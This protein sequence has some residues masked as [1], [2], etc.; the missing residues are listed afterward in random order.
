MRFFVGSQLRA[1][2]ALLVALLLATTTVAG[3]LEI[4]DAYPKYME[5]R[6]F[7]RISEFFSG[8]ENTSNRVIARS[9]P[10]ERSGL[11]FVITLDGKTDRRFLGATTQ[12]Q[13]IVPDEA[14]TRL[15]SI[16]LPIEYP[17]SRELLVGITGAD[18]P[19]SETVP[20]AWKITLFDAHD[21]I[22]AQKESYLWSDRQTGHPTDSRR[23]AKEGKS[24]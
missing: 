16:D 1:D 5:A 6:S 21:E 3:A 12:V 10:E 22:L 24:H 19:D 4:L 11:Y 9:R 17:K 18:W 13:L 7:A 15:Y 8:V 14:E 2:H 23:N 20:L